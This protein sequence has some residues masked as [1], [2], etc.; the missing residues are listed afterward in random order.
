MDFNSQIIPCC[1]LAQV[2]RF[3]TLAFCDD[4]FFMFGR[5]LELFQV[6]S[7]REWLHEKLL[8]AQLSPAGKRPLQFAFKSW[9]L[10]TRKGKSNYSAACAVCLRCDDFCNI[11][12]NFEFQ[13]LLPCDGPLG[14]YCL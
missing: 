11:Y 7:D 9:H 6:T 4:F 10:R 13:H 1:H 14:K 12:G 2:V 5:R 3:M 8:Q